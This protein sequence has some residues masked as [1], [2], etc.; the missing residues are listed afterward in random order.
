MDATQDFLL[1]K[2]AKL[3]VCH[4]LLTHICHPSMDYGW[5]ELLSACL[6]MQTDQTASFDEKQTE[7][8]LSS[9]RLPVGNIVILQTGSTV[10]C[11]NLIGQF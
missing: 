11:R 9:K 6:N 10:Q 1:L 5:M 7:T 4:C 3:N 8:M 2:E